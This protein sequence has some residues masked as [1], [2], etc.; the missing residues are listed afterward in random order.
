VKNIN[1]AEQQAGST[2][3]PGY[4]YAR[5]VGKQLFV[6][7]QVPNDAD[8]QIVGPDDPAAQARQCLKNLSTLLR[9]HGFGL[10]D[11]QQLTIHVVGERAR[12]TAAW[13]VITKAFPEGVPPAT[14]LGVPVLGYADQLVE[15]DATII[16]P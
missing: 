11:V 13:E 12:L 1:E 2:P 15:I 9:V 14:L 16:K 5:R 7:G 3:T 10:A 8:G 4:H 6:S